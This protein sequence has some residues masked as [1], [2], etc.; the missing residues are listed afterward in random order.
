M[1]AYGAT[2]QIDSQLLALSAA[3]TAPVI[4]APVLKFNKQSIRDIQAGIKTATVRQG[5][6]TFPEGVIK[7]VDNR[8]TSIILQN[9]VTTSKKLRELTEGDAKA[10]GSDSVDELKDQLSR[11][12]PGIEPEDVVTVITF[13]IAPSDAS[14]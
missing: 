7:A 12:F 6:R 5:V 4:V 3:T 11:D 8:G 14:K 1:I 2:A 13:R 10:N 9:V